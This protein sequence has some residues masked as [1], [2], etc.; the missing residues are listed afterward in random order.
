MNGLVF[1]VI[2]AIFLMNNIKKYLGNEK[3]RKSLCIFFFN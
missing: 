2:V 1:V 3:D